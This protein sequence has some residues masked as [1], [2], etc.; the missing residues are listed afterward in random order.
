MPSSL[1][2]ACITPYNLIQQV[3]TNHAIEIFKKYVFFFCCHASGIMQ[4]VLIMLW[5]KYFNKVCI[6]F[7]SNN[8]PLNL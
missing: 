7:L 3:S 5:F 8:Q 6:T 4:D 1:N 2:G